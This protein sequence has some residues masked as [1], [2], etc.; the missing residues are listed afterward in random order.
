MSV[1]KVLTKVTISN[2]IMYQA[3]FMWDWKLFINK[4]GSSRVIHRKRRNTFILCFQLINF[5][6]A[7]IF[8]GMLLKGSVMRPKKK[9]FIGS[10]ML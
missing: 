10:K 3:Q 1:T 5:I 9:D 2:A 8:L 6:V 7:L 4:Q